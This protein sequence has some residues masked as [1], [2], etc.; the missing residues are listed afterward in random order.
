MA[1]AVF[2]IKSWLG[3]NQAADGDT[4]LKAG[5]LSAMQNFRITRE[6][7][8]Q[9]RPGT[10]TVLE[11]S[12]AWTEWCKTHTASTSSPVL[13][14][15]WYGRV[16]GGA[17]V[18]ASYG[19][20][21]WSIDPASW[22]A[23]ARGTATQSPTV[24]FGF[25]DKAYLLNG[26][27]YQVWDGGAATEFSDVSGYI[28]T[29]LTAASP[30]GSGTELEGVN[31]LCGW[32][33]VRF[34]PDGTSTVFHLP[35]QSVSEI[36]TVDG[37]TVTHTD[38]LTAGTLTFASAP[39]AGTNTVTVTYRKGTG[40]RSEVTGMRFCELY[41]GSTDAR[42]FLY[43]DGTNRAIYSGLTGDG[44]PS[45][46]YFP[47]LYELR[48]GEDNTPITAMVRHYGQLLCFKSGSAWSVRYGTLTL[49]DDRTTAAFYVTPINRQFGN[50]APGQ[51][52][53]LENDALTLDGRSAYL[54][55]STSSS[56][57]YT[58]TERNC[59]RCSDRVETALSEM[60]L[61]AAV[62]CNFKEE[63]E[64]YIAQGGRALIY[65]YAANA[66]YLYTEFP[67]AFLLDAEGALYLGTAEGK[68]KAVSRTYRG[69]DGAE[70]AC[71]AE[72]GSMDFGADW[73]RKYET[74]LWIAMKP[75]SGGRVT[76]T[77]MSNRRSDYPEK[78]V[79][80]SLSTFTHVNFAHWS[81]GTNRQPQVKRV[82]LKVKKATFIKLVFVSTSASDTA[83]ILSVDDAV[84]TG[85]KVK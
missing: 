11:L 13:S 45:A 43:G 48:A 2:S 7:H 71:R 74:V 53:L 34:S 81:F 68:I 73:R 24:F 16:G 59:R 31:R 25:S 19:G 28:P 6:G 29:I 50:D 79:A 12:A 60:D 46:E 70:I 78:V 64:Y 47:D 23:T 8:L 17:V 85:G 40:A 65:N 9:K 55:K 63:H 56:G 4:G 36:G 66:W 20:V 69:D 22:T 14:G 3:L 33:K 72:T 15:L 57:G 80:S 58:D 18:L 84:R 83:T 75:E 44:E 41:N 67:A 27:E 30:D 49:A 35:E 32:R 1:A 51:V 77:A 21:L 42:V 82:K 10:H 37:T 54:W 61:T 62:T 39:A 38:D 5:E 26:S 76:V 52:K